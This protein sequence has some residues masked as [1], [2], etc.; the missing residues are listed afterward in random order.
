M[1]NHPTAAQLNELLG[2]TLRTYV[3]PGLLFL[4]E[5]SYPPIDKQG[6]DLNGFGWRV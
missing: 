1:I 5:L 2:K 6:A 4:D 3:R